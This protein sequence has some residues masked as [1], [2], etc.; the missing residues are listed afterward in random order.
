[1]K[2]LE[3]ATFLAVFVTMGMF[4]ERHLG[5]GPAVVLSL[6]IV[7]LPVAIFALMYGRKA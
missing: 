5:T 2:W 3:R 1:M 6:V 4:F 7:F